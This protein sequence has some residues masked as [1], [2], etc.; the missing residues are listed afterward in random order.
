MSKDSCSW[1]DIVGCCRSLT[2]RENFGVMW[3]GVLGSC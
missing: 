2:R 1:C 3:F